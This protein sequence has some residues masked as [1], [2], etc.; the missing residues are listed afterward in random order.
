MNVIAY[1]QN[2][3]LE[4][5]IMNHRFY[6]KDEGKGLIEVTPRLPDMFMGLYV[7]QD[8]FGHFVEMNIDSLTAGRPEIA[9][10]SKNISAKGKIT[11]YP[12]N[13]RTPGIYCFGSSKLTLSATQAVS[14]GGA[15]STI[16]SYFQDYTC[17]GID[18]LEVQYLIRRVMEGSI[19]PREA[20]NKPQVKPL[21]IQFRD[22][23]MMGWRLVRRD[24]FRCKGVY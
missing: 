10:Y 21:P 14:S 24:L 5:K 7:K 1:L 18:F 16:T 9:K 6:L 17:E 12:R 15:H 11:F 22:W 23:V 19:L 3:K 20:H 8:G 13:E 4:P 2:R